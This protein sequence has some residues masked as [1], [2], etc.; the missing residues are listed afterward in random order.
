M[1][2]LLG[3]IPFLV[4]ASPETFEST[5]KFYYAEQRVVESQARLQWV[6]DDLE[7]L[8]LTMLFHASFTDPALQYDALLIA[9]QDH[10]ARA[11]VLGNGTFRGFYV[12]EGLVARDVT[13]AA[14]AT[15]LAIRVQVRL[16]EWAP[17]TALAGTSA[18][19]P[20]S[21]PLAIASTA[22][23]YPIPALA[24]VSAGP[25]STYLPP[26]FAT[27]GVSALVDNFV[28]SAAAG[29]NASYSDVP[30]ATIVRRSQ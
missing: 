14:D 2:A 13:L 23:S 29:P 1:F 20:A 22:I 19:P 12:L 26:T 7:K 18:P 11:L 28:A 6:G 30:P 16:C 21:T 25:V 17:D 8:T 5:R 27:P 24:G 15:P 4:L 10:Q 9:A 3:E